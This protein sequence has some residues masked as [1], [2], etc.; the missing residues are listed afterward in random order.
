M[1][2]L[3]LFD[4]LPQEYYRQV[5][6]FKAKKVGSNLSNTEKSMAKAYFGPRNL[7][8]NAIGAYHESHKPINRV[9][10]SQKM[11]NINFWIYGLKVM[12]EVNGI[13]KTKRYQII[14]KFADEFIN[15]IGL[16]PFL[17]LGQRIEGIYHGNPVKELRAL[18]E[19]KRFFEFLG[20]PKFNSQVADLIQCQKDKLSIVRENNP[21][22]ET[23]TY[24]RMVYELSKL[25]ITIVGND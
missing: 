20:V 23:E 25:G 13:N 4:Q 18:Y 9:R 10:A 19:L 15:N 22:Y 24:R 2:Q 7:M 8:S 17:F 3:C 14:I 5:R 11:N 16:C 21:E 6:R 12:R 1:E